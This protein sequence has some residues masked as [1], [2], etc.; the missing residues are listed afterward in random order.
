MNE[1]SEFPEYCQPQVFASARLRSTTYLRSNA[2]SSAEASEAIS[3]PISMEVALIWPEYW[4]TWCS[5]KRFLDIIES[6]CLKGEY[7]SLIFAE[8]TGGKSS[9]RSWVLLD[10]S[11]FFSERGGRSAPNIPIHVCQERCTTSLG[12]G[13]PIPASRIPERNSMMIPPAM[14]LLLCKLSWSYK[15]TPYTLYYWANKETIFILNLKLDKRLYFMPY[16]IP[17]S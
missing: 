7:A 16:F 8:T 12:D 10:L 11:N 13:S 14:V 2:S 4:W 6:R 3:E 17:S 9:L 1:I 15:G 5:V